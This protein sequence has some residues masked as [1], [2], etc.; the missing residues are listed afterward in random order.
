MPGAAL[1]EVVDITP[2]TAKE[3]AMT[4]HTGRIPGADHLPGN[5][6]LEE[7]IRDANADDP[8]LSKEPP[9]ADEVDESKV[10]GDPDDRPA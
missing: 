10:A 3:K 9:D 4:D 6:G 2:P 1:G 8:A 7:E 5:K